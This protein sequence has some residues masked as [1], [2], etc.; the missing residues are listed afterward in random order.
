MDEVEGHACCDLPVDSSRIGIAS[1]TVHVVPL[2]IFP[3]MLIAFTVAAPILQ[4][5]LATHWTAKAAG[6]FVL[7]ILAKVIARK[8]VRFAAPCTIYGEIVHAHMLLSF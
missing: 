4:P 7:L 8:S 1:E 3:W 5:L 6:S 2:M